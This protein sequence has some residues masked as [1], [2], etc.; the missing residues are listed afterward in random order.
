[1]VHAPGSRQCQGYP[2]Y[3]QSTGTSVEKETYSPD[4]PR[5]WTQ[6]LMNSGVKLSNS[7]TI[8]VA[9]SWKKTIPR[10]PVIAE[11]PAVVMTVAARFILFSSCWIGQAF[12]VNRGFGSRLAQT[13]HY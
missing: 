10:E 9:S 6:R 13:K 5:G 7:Y 8:E 12:Y 2:D 3:V 4:E 1:M 11:V